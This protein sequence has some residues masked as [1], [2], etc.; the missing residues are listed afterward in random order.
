MWSL[1]ALCNCSLTHI[2]QKAQ[3]QTA[4]H[5]SKVFHVTPVF[6]KSL[7]SIPRPCALAHRAFDG[8]KPKV[9]VMMLSKFDLLHRVSRPATQREHAETHAR[10][11]PNTASISC[12]CSNVRILCSFVRPLLDTISSVQRARNVQ[13]QVQGPITSPV[14][15]RCTMLRRK[16]KW[17]RKITHVKL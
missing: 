8:S 15:Y 2:E 13:M 4:N 1:S 3:T 7:C 11:G 10:L 12:T 6:H 9:A 5:Y 17:G 14:R 16:S